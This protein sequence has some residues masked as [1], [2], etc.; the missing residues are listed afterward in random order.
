ML[1][2]DRPI[3]PG[4]VTLYDIWPG[5][6][7]GLF[8]Q[9]RPRSPHGAVSWLVFNGA[10]STKRLHRTMKHIMLGWGKKD[11]HTIQQWQNT[12]KQKS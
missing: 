12:I 9:P 1:R 2:Y 5:N 4:L 10:F 7:P 6:G 3:K 11:K 8:L